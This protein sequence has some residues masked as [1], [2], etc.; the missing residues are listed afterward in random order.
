MANATGEAKTG[1]LRLQFALSERLL[2]RG[3]AI[4]SWISTRSWITTSTYLDCAQNMV[5]KV[6]SGPKCEPCQM[7][8]KN[9]K[10]PSPGGGAG[11]AGFAENSKPV[12]S[13]NLEF[14]SSQNLSI[15]H[16]S[17]R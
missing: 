4:R 3:S 15:V 6:R 7:T 2:F 17:S 13:L 11:V 12:L 8:A 1:P 10:R 14:F 16:I 9:G 5:G